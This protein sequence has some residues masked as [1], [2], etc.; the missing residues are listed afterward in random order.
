MK[1]ELTEEEGQLL[2]HYR[3]L[4]PVFQGHIRGLVEGLYGI[5]SYRDEMAAKSISQ[6]KEAGV[7]TVKGAGV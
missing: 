6:G 5:Q 2:E 7:E 4:L 3:A 1:Y